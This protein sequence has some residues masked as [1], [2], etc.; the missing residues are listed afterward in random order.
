MAK[1]I[2]QLYSIVL[3]IVAGFVPIATTTV[4][5]PGIYRG[6]CEIQLPNYEILNQVIL[7]LISLSTWAIVTLVFAYKVLT[8]D[9]NV[10]TFD[11]KVLT[12]L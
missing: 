5:S 1:L 10:L 2:P 12:L 9:Y 8:F 7:V 4:P 6:V 11:Y 3:L